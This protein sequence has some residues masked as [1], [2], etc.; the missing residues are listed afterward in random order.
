MASR[1]YT[2]LFSTPSADRFFGATP[3][4]SETRAGLCPALLNMVNNIETSSITAVVSEKGIRMALDAELSGCRLNGINLYGHDINAGIYGPY[5]GCIEYDVHQRIVDFRSLSADLAYNRMNV[6]VLQ[7]TPGAYGSPREAVMLAYDGGRAAGWVR[8]AHSDFWGGGAEE[9]VAAA[10]MTSASFP[11]CVPGW[12]IEQPVSDSTGQHSLWYAAGL[13][14]TNTL[15]PVK[16]PKCAAWSEADAAVCRVNVRVP[17]ERSFP[18]GTNAKIYVGTSGSVEGLR[19][20]G[21]F[22]AADRDVIVNG[23][24]TPV[25]NAGEWRPFYTDEFELSS[26]G[27]P[28]YYAVSA[29]VVLSSNL[30]ALGLGPGDDN[31]ALDPDGGWAGAAE[32]SFFYDRVI[33]AN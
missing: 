13:C 27:D 9:G 17:L 22:Y 20:W 23:R 30:L 6:S 4:V 31:Y 25:E 7:S 12:F 5:S 8:R 24:T 19:W 33:Y 1:T 28:A 14:R 10:Y 16:D 11:I 21:W 3:M 32:V 29:E 26:R 18:I 2:T 15:L